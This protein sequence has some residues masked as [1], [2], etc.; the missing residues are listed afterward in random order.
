[1]RSFIWS[2][3]FFESSDLISI[4]H[5][6]FLLC[7]PSLGKLLFDRVG[8]AL[9]VCS[10]MR[11]P[12]HLVQDA[13]TM[14]NDCYLHSDVLSMDTECLAMASILNACESHPSV[15][16]GCVSKRL[17]GEVGSIAFEQI[18]RVSNWMSGA[19]LDDSRPCEG[20]FI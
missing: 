3:S 9:L 4:S 1:M 8:K 17:E 20:A 11:L 16:V 13:W 7:Y 5:C 18:V 6:R 19:H 10:R 15:A 14:L 2:T 12:R